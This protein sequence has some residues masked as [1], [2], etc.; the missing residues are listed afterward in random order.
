MNTCIITIVKIDKMYHENNLKELISPIKLAGTRH[1][2]TVDLIDNEYL[3]SLIL[4]PK[5][6]INS[7]SNEGISS[8]KV[9]ETQ[10]IPIS[11]IKRLHQKNYQRNIDQV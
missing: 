2:I 8:Y 1:F 5:G 10:K 4:I 9:L 11:S 7:K 3:L 6:L